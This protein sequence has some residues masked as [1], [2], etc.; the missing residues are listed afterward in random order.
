MVAKNSW[1]SDSTNLTPLSV[2]IRVGNRQ[3]RFQD[4][5]LLRFP[6]RDRRG[7]GSHLLRFVKVRGRILE[8]RCKDVPKVD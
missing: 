5:S 7:L 6:V 3:E 8:V 1:I 2:K 4:G